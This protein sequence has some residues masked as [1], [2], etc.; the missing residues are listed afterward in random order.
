M[1]TNMPP[2]KPSAPVTPGWNDPPPMVSKPT[3]NP[4]HKQNVMQFDWKPVETAPV[5]GGM[6]MGHQPNNFSGGVA[7]HNVIANGIQGMKL[8]NCNS[9]AA[10]SSYPSP[11]S[12]QQRPPSVAAVAAP[13]PIQLFTRR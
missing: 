5:P 12:Y 13:P 1:P 2:P 10:S 3:P 11:S 7:Y 6:M 9:S 4:Q 8:E